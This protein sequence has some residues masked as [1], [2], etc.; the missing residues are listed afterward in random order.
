M[1]G[2]SF[3]E[4]THINRSLSALGDV[5]ANL[6]TKAAHI[7]FRNSKLTCVLQVSWARTWYLFVWQQVQ[8]C[9]ML[10][11]ELVRCNVADSD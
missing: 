11:F 7:P 2:Q 1:E 5:I 8:A 3:K 6:Q 9:R 4:A 10:S